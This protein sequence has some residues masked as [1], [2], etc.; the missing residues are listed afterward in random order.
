[1]NRTTLLTVLALSVALLATPFIG[2]ALAGVGQETEYFHFH[3]EGLGTAVWDDMWDS[4]INR[5]VRG[6]GFASLGATYVMLG[7]ELI[8]ADCLG[9]EASMDVQNHLEKGFFNVQVD[10][11]IYIYTDAEQE[12][13]RG[14]IEIQALG[15]NK[16]GNGGNFVGFGTGEFEEVK[17]KG[18]SLPLTTTPNPAPPP[19]NFNVLDRIGIAMGL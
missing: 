10:E 7:D 11:I 13:L 15:T 9:Y 4:G 14:T 18:T 1:M 5:H 8:E 16:P 6:R 17:V 2:T 12:T 3:L 19:A